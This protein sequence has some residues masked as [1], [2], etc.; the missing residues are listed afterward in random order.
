LRG[1]PDSQ[2]FEDCAGLEDLDGLVVRDAP[3]ARAL[4]RFA[5][6][7]PFLLETDERSSHGPA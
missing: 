7:E 4:V 6:D 2:P 3:H 1:E 5:D